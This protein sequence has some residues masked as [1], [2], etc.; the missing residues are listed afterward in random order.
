MSEQSERDDDAI[1]A[2]MLLEAESLCRSKDALLCGQYRHLQDR[3]R[4]LIELRE[5]FQAKAE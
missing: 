5:C 1:L 3:I 2:N 4:A